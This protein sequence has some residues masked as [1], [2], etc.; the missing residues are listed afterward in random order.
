MDVGTASADVLT[1]GARGCSPDVPGF[2]V[3]RLITCSRNVIHKS[4]TDALMSEQA[5]T[6][7][8]EV[9]SRLRR[10]ARRIGLADLLSG[11]VVLLLVL[12]SLWFIA[13]LAESLLWLPVGP[14]SAAFWA[15]LLVVVVGSFVFVLR[16]VARLTGLIPGPR[17]EDIARRI[18]TRYPEVS[19]KM[20]NLLDLGRGRHSPSESMVVSAAVASLARQIVPVPFEEVERFDV[21]KRLARF[22]TVPLL[23]LLAFA[24][25][26]PTSFIGASARLLAPGREFVRPASF[27]FSVQPGNARVLR[28]EALEI[29]A[30]VT[31]TNLPHQAVLATRFDGDRRPEETPMIADSSAMFVHVVSNVRRSFEYRLESGGIATPWYSVAVLQRPVVAELRL[32]L[33]FPRYSR[34]PRQVLESNVGDVTALPGTLVSLRVTSDGPDLLQAVVLHDDGRV[35]SL[36]ASSRSASGSFRVRR[37]GTYQIRLVSVDGIENESPISYAVRVL[38]D[39]SPTVAIVKPDPIHE[40]DGSEPVDVAIRIADDF[41]FRDLKLAYRVSESRFG[42]VDS[43]F[44]EIELPIGNSADLLRDIPFEW[45]LSRFLENKIV[46]G[47]EVEYYAVVRDNDAVSGYK[48]ATSSTYKLVV[49]SLADKLDRLDEM[50]DDAADTMERMQEQSKEL[51][52]QFDEMRRELQNDP[53]PDWDDERRLDQMERQQQSV[54]ETAQQLSQ[55]LEEMTSRM[56]EQE[57]LSPDTREM[58]EEL[59]RVV[60]EIDSEELNDALQQLREAM[61][62]LDAQQMQKA[63]DNFEFN[64]EQYKERLQRS[65]DL[66]EKLQMQQQ[67]EEIAE[68]AK[69]LSEKQEQMS[70]ET[71]QLERKGESA[72][73]TSEERNAMSDE[74]KQSAEQ[75]RDI[76]ERLEEM[77]QKMQDM[78]N[79][80]KDAF[81]DLKDQVDRQS[82]PERM[83]QNA[84]QMEQNQLQPASQGQQQMSQDLQKM[85]MQMSQMQQGMQGMQMQVDLEGLRRAL[86]DILLLSERQEEQKDRLSGQG[87]T[88]GSFREQARE[89]LRL[90]ESFRS[91]R[92]SLVALASSIPQMTSQVQEESASVLREMAEATSSMSEGVSRRATGHQ[93][94]AMMHLNELALLLSDLMSALNN[95]SAQA[96]GGQSMEQM[97]QQLQQMAN[98]QQQLNGQIQQLLNDMAGQRLTTDM[99]Q[100]MRELAGQQEAIRKQ[101][102]ELSRNPEL[103]GKALGDLKRIAEQME[104]TIRELEGRRGSRRTI[105]RQQQ[106]LTRLLESTRSLQERERDKKRESQTAEEY[107]FDQPD[108]LPK[109]DQLDRLRRE[110]IRALDAGYS[111]DY[112]ELIKRYFDLLQERSN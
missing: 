44:S 75:M 62:N 91:V 72:E 87:E 97:M 9:E 37:D 7:L 94:S 77:E 13:T 76:E 82:L 79:V 54:E 42:V 107:E 22:L 84:E 67:M 64:E 88:T 1:S 95:S 109:T 8:T 104:E 52:R 53:N 26:A 35:D 25:A 92:D 90:E 14:R 20:V 57:L 2:I 11:L 41:G 102:H 61:Q 71:R 24:L 86:N 69:E 93:Q 81:E 10:T 4:A 108:E 29:S 50:G 106:I 65:L 3:E 33:D 58:F 16:P 17:D 68:L 39:S 6:L 105:E 85:Q 70:E 45:D 89:Q 12:G 28:G 19:D 55:Q 48:S 27:A 36:D 78:Q 49:P 63:M 30:G 96:G 101:L 59:R 15:L 56:D 31:G 112:E 66:L 46:P 51:R 34:I 23:A 47:N 103:R 99:E 38:D 110:L 32:E 18:G 5:I 43:A 83:E 80:P 60:E 74:Q 21:P 73:E 111:P 40:V 100:R 98:D